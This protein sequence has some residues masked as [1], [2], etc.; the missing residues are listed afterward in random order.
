MDYPCR[1]IHKQI[2]IM[3]KADIV[4][5]VAKSTGIEATTVMAFLEGFMEQSRM[6]LLRRRTSTSKD[7]A[8]SK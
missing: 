8:H 1:I 2:Q 3:T 4:K 7:S 5:E 6:H